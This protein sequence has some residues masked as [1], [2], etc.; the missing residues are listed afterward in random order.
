MDRLPCFK[1]YDIRGR[2]GRDLTPALMR[3]IGAGFVATLAP[4]DKPLV[5][6]GRDIR[7]SS[8][9]LAAALAAGVCSAGADVADLGLCA[10]E[11]VYFA[12][13]HLKAGGGLMVTASHNP[14]EDNGLKLVGAGAAPLAPARF[15]ALHDL[16][17]AP[18]QDSAETGAQTRFGQHHPAQ[19]RPAYVARLLS[20]VDP[21]RLGPLRIVTDA[22]HGA[23][24]PAFDA[25]AEALAGQGADL[26][27]RR[28]WHRPDPAFPVGIPNPMLPGSRART[29]RAVVDHG[30]DFGIAW[31][32]DAD[33]CF[34]F[35]DQGQ[36][37]AGDYIVA[38]LAR[39]MLRR[40]P[41][42]RIIHDPRVVRA[43][44]A[45]V[46]GAGGTPVAAPTGHAR[47]KAA[48]RAED[49]VYGGELSAHHYFRDFA[50]CDSGMI[51]WMLIAAE[52]SETGARLSDLLAD[53]R[54]SYLSSGEINFPHPD[55]AA[56]MAR[57]AA[58][59]AAQ[60][61][62]IDQ[63]DGL[64]LTFA[65]WRLNLRCSSTEAL[66]RLNLES[67]GDAELLAEKLAEV[68]ALVAQDM[69]PTAPVV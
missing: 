62:Q 13:A 19:T 48:M 36:F 40:A 18:P 34:F 7:A 30:A 6:I 55:P 65:D 15:A 51:P 32:G 31:D 1:T 16:V 14:I 12:T 4:Q 29:A 47:I 63:M 25:L 69:A 20:F 60:A 68:K 23:A 21:A 59:Y 37:V 50:F 27:F 24:A 35:D 8:P 56:A 64:S 66:L 26:R 41:G 43:I 46:T 44:R 45:A 53:L 38:L 58:H 52:L 10:T 5:V 2:L 57:V 42:S 28:L 61:P 49:A 54:Q 9:D 17:Q 67:L 3:R 11:E 39:A 33:R 22:G